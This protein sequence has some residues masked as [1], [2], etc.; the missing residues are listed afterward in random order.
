MQHLQHLIDADPCDHP[1]L[2]AHAQY[3]WGAMTWR[4]RCST[5]AMIAVAT[6]LLCGSVTVLAAL[7]SM[8]AG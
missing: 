2:L 4:E 8:I 5:V 1:S 6:T 7:C 3:Y